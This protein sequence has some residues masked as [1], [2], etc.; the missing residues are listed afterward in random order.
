[1][2]RAIQADVQKIH[3]SIADLESNTTTVKYTTTNIKSDTGALLDDTVVQ[4]KAKLMKCICSVDYHV[5]HKDF[6]KPHQTGTGRWF[7]EDPKFEAWK[8]SKN[9]TLFCPGVPGAGKTTMAALI[10]DHLQSQ[11]TDKEPV[12]FIYCDY[13]RQSEQSAEHMLSAL[14]RQIIE[15]QPA[16]PK[17][18]QDSYI[19]P[20]GKEVTPS[21]EKVKQILGTASKNLHALTVV[22]DALDEC[23]RK[24][25]EDFLT[26]V[27]DLRKQCDIR[28]LATSRFVPIIENRSS[29]LGRPTLEIKASDE[30]LGKYIRSRACE[31]ASNLQRI[32]SKPNGPK[33]LEDLV[34]ETTK[35][36]GGMYA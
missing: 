2:T 24:A 28:L 17:D 34:S 13:K 4:H 21:W 1:M 16:V 29:F 12:T 36:T 7:V 32:L 22:I 18:V 3:K 15:S 11:H 14:L 8:R 33:L 35:A 30:D 26:A 9:T 10:I 31:P 19:T 27:E 5:Q 23:E 6:I 25:R 20:T